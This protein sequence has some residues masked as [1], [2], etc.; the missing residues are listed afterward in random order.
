MWPPA[1]PRQPRRARTRAGMGRLVRAELRAHWGRAL[2]LGLGVVAATTAFTVLTGA[3]EVERL[4]L[5]GEVVAAQDDYHILVRPPGSRSELEAVAGL[6][7]P[8]QL[9]GQFGGIALD[10]YDAIRELS[11]VEVAAP[12]AMVGYVMTATQVAVEAGPRDETGR[13]LLVADVVHTTDRG[14]TAI[15]QP[16][17]SYSYVTPNPIT[18][19]GPAGDDAAPYG[20]VETAP[21]GSTTLVCPAWQDLASAPDVPA[22]A[23]RERSRTCESTQPGHDAAARQWQAPDQRTVV[24]EWSFPMLVAA[25]DPAQEAALNQG[26]GQPASL[27]ALGDAPPASGTGSRPVPVVVAAEPQVDAQAEVTVRELPG[28]AAD[29]LASGLTLE[30]VGELLTTP[31]AVVATETVTAQ[32]AYE[33]LVEQARTSGTNIVVD[34]FWTTLPTTYDVGADG[35]LAPRPVENPWDVWRS[36]LRAGGYVPA[37]PL[38]ADTGFREVR[39]HPGTASGQSQ[40]PQMQIVGVFDDVEAAEFDGAHGLPPAD[41]RSSELLGGVPLLPSGSPAAY[42]LGPPTAFI[43]L[44][45]LETFTRSGIEL[46]EPDAPISAVR[47]RVAGVSGVSAVERER[48]RLVADQIR[49]A[50]GLDVDVVLGSSATEQT[51]ALPEGAFGRPELALVETWLRQG[52]VAAVMRAVDHKSVAL[53]VLVL[54]VSAL[55]VANVSAASA[56]SRRGELAVLSRV[57]WSRRHILRLLLTEVMLVGGAAGVTGALVSVAVGRISGLD[58]T[59][60]RA[61]VAIPAAVLVAL[62]AAAFPAWRA[63]RPATA[64]VL[65]PGGVRVRRMA[66]RAPTVR[67]LWSLAVANVVRSPGRTGLGVVAVALGCAA[68]TVLLGITVA[69]HG[70][71]VGSVLGDAVSLRAR[72]IDYVAALVTVALSSVAVADVVFLNVRDRRAEIAV[73]QAVGW[74]DGRVRRLVLTEAALIGLAGAVLGTVAGLVLAAGLAGEFQPELVVVAV[75]TVAGGTAVPVLASLVPAAAL[76]RMT[77]ATTLTRDA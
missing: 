59:A 34:S 31:G 37:P 13:E 4:E 54:A 47:V 8:Y 45:D 41:A 1:D 62:G 69:F 7:R 68:L 22:T 43:R 29:R 57:G 58:V 61:A 52:V 76:R 6:V 33:V 70:A 19:V 74:G 66:A 75:T 5:R 30:Q 26:S 21:D 25:V 51:V 71:V 73:L 20:L 16:A 53:F 77:V 65:Q 38:V 50:T 28:E 14:L 55:F 48:V 23:A 17:A 11:G 10:D 12:V 72:E 35:V 2:A 56:R 40:L 63:S 67:G 27:L 60:D 18:F 36:P 15:E 44:S 32:Q 24:V 64:A 42:H 3:S 49:A 9:S 46:A 39:P